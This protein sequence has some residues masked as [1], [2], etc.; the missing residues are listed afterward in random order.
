MKI[1]SR[2]Y[3]RLTP[4]ERFKAAVEAFGRKDYDEV[5]RLNEHCPTKAYRVQEPAY[6]DRLRK[7][8]FIAL[9]HA[10]AVREDAMAIT[11]CLAAMY[12]ALAEPE[13][14]VALDESSE[15]QPG[16][17]DAMLEQASDLVDIYPTRRRHLIA[18][19]AAFDDFCQEIGL[20]PESVRR[21]CDISDLR[22]IFATEGAT[23]EKPDA[24]AVAEWREGLR[25]MW[26]KGI[27]ERWPSEHYA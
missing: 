14:E 23:A 26:R 21:M 17:Y 9:F 12:R 3:D 4:A 24:S 19:E 1:D 25:G 18:R 15:E 11:G 13:P 16:E 2:I 5:D 10:K 8:P 20:R 22:E 7:L 6:F 27:G